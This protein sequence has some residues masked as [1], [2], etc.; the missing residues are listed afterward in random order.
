MKASVRAEGQ[1]PVQVVIDPRNRQ[2]IQVL[3]SHLK[4][5]ME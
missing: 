4:A 5:S 2:A 3:A 1:E